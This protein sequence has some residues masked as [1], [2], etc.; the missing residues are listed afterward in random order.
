MEIYARKCS[1][2]GEGMNEGWVVDGG[3]MYFSKEEDALK[4]C[5]EHGY[6]SIEDAYEDDVIY[7]TDWHDDESDWQYVKLEDGTV[8]EI[9]DVSTEQTD[10]EKVLADVRDYFSDL[11]DEQ[12]EELIPNLISI[13]SNKK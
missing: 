10:N 2:T 3:E 7:W 8:V 9:E 1:I 11:T 5:I 6:E 4:W 13:L 12:I